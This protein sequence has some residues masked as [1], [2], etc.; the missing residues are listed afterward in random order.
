MTL[1]P[2]EYYGVDAD[3]GSLSP[4]KV[5]DVVFLEDLA[6]MD[7]RRVM[8]DGE[9]VVDGGEWLP[10]DRRPA[11]ALPSVGDHTETVRA[12]FPESA[13]D[14]VRGTPPEPD[15]FRIDA[16]TDDGG[17]P[18]DRV[19]VEAIVAR[20]NRAD[21]GRTTVELPVVDGA[22]A[23]PADVDVA[24]AFVFDRHDPDGSA[25]FGFATG[26]DFERGAVAST[27]AHDSHN[28]LVVGRDDAAMARA[29]ERLHE[30]GG[31]M[32][33][34]DGAASTVAGAADASERPVLA[35]VPLPVAGLMSDRPLA[36]VTDQV[37][38]LH[39]AWRDLGCDLESPFMTLSLLALPVI[40]ALRVTARGVVDVTAFEFVDPVRP[41]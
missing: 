33:A 28:L 19:T 10:A 35:T 6:S 20:E 27:V 7:V 1:A 26:F 8:V 22:V 18:V 21:T 41:V 36:T 12:A 38:A 3:L 2:A 9:L 30:T 15:A 5:A 32:V 13:R 23:I 37:D 31:G 34:V 17:D 40:P 29:A 25:G 39:D 4:G 16:P 11:H 24:K 14:T